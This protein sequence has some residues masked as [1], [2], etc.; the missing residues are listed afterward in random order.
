LRPIRHW[1]TQNS[2]IG[3]SRSLRAS[4]RGEPREHRTEAA[5]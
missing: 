5:R 2:S 3:T 1:S 4:M